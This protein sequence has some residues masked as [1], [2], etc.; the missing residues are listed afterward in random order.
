[1]V[2]SPWP[3]TQEKSSSRSID[4]KISGGV[5]VEAF[6]G[7]DYCGGAI[8]GDDGGAGVGLAWLEF[9]AGADRGCEFLAIENHRDFEPGE[10]AELRS[11]WTGKSARSHMVY[12]ADMAHL[13][14]AGP[15]YF[16][17]RRFYRGPQAEGY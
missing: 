7:G 3:G 9:F 14:R 15:G 8:F 11:A 10:R 6:A 16:Q 5:E 12:L 4:H 2:G 13:A 17:G 1:M